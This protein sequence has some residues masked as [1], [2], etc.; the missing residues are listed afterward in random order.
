MQKTQELWSW[1]FKVCIFVH[2]LWRYSTEWANMGS[3]ACGAADPEEVFFGAGTTVYS[4]ERGWEN[5]GSVLPSSCPGGPAHQPVLASGSFLIRCSQSP[6]DMVAPISASP[7][8]SIRREARRQQLTLIGLTGASWISQ[9][10]LL[11]PWTVGWKI[12]NHLIAMDPPQL[13]WDLSL[14]CPLGSTNASWNNTSKGW[15]LASKSFCRKFLCTLQSQWGLRSWVEPGSRRCRGSLTA[16]ANYALRICLSPWLDPSWLLLTVDGQMS[17]CIS[18][19][20]PSS[21][22]C[23]WTQRAMRIALII[24]MRASAH[25]PLLKSVD[26]SGSKK[27]KPDAPLCIFQE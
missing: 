27:P 25:C 9:S 19:L 3:V 26:R 12:M 11:T 13:I 1:L 16:A 6:V 15:A 17:A 23:L 2:R 5:S 10:I 4:Q 7:V 14:P 22:H 18:A 20:A 8:R 24:P 21:V